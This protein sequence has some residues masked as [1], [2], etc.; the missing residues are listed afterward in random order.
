MKVSTLLVV[1]CLVAATWLSNEFLISGQGPVL[2]KWED[3]NSTFSIRVERRADLY[4]LMSYWYVFQSS[5]KGTLRWGEITRQLHGEPVPLPKEQIRFVSDDVG[6]LFFQLKYAVTVDSGQ[7]WSV[8]D[9]GHNPL[10]SPKKLDYSRIADVKVL[11]DGTG[12]LTMFR[13][14]ITQGQST[15][16]FTHD[17]GRHWELK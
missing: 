9:F 14:D 5:R 8:F 2:E 7:S 15:L 6:Y 4:S 12:K 13:Y 16:F 17:Y 3:H 1:A 11:P 10:Y